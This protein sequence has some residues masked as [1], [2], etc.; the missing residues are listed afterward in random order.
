VRMQIAWV[1]TH[2]SVAAATAS[3]TEGKL[4]TAHLVGSNGARRRVA[5]EQGVGVDLARDVQAAHPQ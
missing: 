1:L 2:I 3:F 4:T 5:G